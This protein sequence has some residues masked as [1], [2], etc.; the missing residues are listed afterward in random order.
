MRS[1]SPDKSD[2]SLFVDG[3]HLLELFLELK[4]I[5]LINAVLVHP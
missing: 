3:V 5:L 2:Y 4:L 1:C